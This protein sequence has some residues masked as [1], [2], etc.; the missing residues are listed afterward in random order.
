MEHHEQ[1]HEQVSPQMHD[2]AVRPVFDS[3]KQHGSRWQAIM[4]IAAKIGCSA[5]TLNDWVKK[6][7]GDGGNAHG[8]FQWNDR[9]H[10]LFDFIGGQ[11]NLG[12]VQKQLE[13]AWHEL[14]TSENGPF[15]QLMASTDVRGATEAFVGFERPRNYSAANPA[16]SLHFDRR[17]AAAEAAMSRFESATVT[18]QQQL[19]QLG[20][21]AANPGSGLQDFGAGLAGVIQNA[22]AQRGLGGMLIGGLLTGAGKAI[23]IPGF[24][25]GGFTGPG[26]TT[27]VAGLV[28]AG[29]FVFDAATTR[30]IGVA[31][32][33][34]IRSGAMRGYREGGHVTGGRPLPMPSAAGGSGSAEAR[35]RDVNFNINVTGT[36]AAEI[37]EAVNASIAQA[38]DLFDREALPDR[39]K[40]IVHDRWGS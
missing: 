25:Q 2:R 28:H 40:M 10:K 20:A 29:E 37:H 18:A 32:L 3:E 36:G 4:S 30:R 12:D 23:G 11:Q 34:A 24:E 6:A 9:R 13:F 35:P 15:R 38:F 33:E 7:L 31:N 14:M 39:V 1:D 19:G 17:L 22:G 27:D 5:H 8:L 26:Q 21:G 16:G